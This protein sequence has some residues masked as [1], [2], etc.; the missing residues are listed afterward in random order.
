M[1]T[2]MIGRLWKGTTTTSRT[3]I[4]KFEFLQYHIEQAIVALHKIEN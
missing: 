2:Y 4:W 3:H 1:I